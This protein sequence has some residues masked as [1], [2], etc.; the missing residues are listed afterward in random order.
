M[1]TEKL[2]GGWELLGRLQIRR[3]R[4]PGQLQ[5]KIVVVAL[6]P[7]TLAP[8]SLAFN[9]ADKATLFQHLYRL[10]DGVLREATPL[11]DGFDAGPAFLFLSCGGEQI[12]V[13]SE[14]IWRQAIVENDVWHL[15]KVCCGCFHSVLLKFLWY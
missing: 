13:D 1:R 10:A 11:G 2:S 12:G 7:L 15:I 3:R 5:N 14:L 4:E 8:L 6:K 9:L